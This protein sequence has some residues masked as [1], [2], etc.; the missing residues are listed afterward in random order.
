[1]TGVQT[2]ALPIWKPR[3]PADWE[4]DSSDSNGKSENRKE[5]ASSFDPKKADEDSTGKSND[6]MSSDHAGDTST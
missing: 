5:E 6:P 4:N 2:C 3:P 1:V